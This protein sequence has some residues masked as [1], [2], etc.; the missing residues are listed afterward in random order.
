MR[1]DYTLPDANLVIQGHKDYYYLLSE[2]QYLFPFTL[3]D[4][5]PRAPVTSGITLIFMFHIFL[6]SRSK[7]W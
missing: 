5:I 6:N 1:H 2:I 3:M 4:V 7:S